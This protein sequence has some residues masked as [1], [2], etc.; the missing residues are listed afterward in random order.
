MKRQAMDYLVAWK[1]SKYRK[2]LLIRGAAR[3]GKTWILKEFGDREF[4][5]T[6]YISFADNRQMERLFEGD[7]SP[8]RL[9][10]G[11]ELESGVS[12]T[13]DTLLILDDIEAVPG[14]VSAV[15]RLCD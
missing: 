14:A 7:L 12:I 6:A 1:K 5:S 8:Q 3:V 2:L 4:S 13:S 9:L 10:Q 15:L 11:F